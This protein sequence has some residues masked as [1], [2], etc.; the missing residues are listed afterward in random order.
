MASLM[1]GVATT[2]IDNYITELNAQYAAH[3][4]PYTIISDGPGYRLILR[5]EFN[6]LR[7]AC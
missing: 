5:P 7:N 2:E 1:R 3:G 6:A 4:C